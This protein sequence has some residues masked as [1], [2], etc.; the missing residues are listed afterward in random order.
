MCIQQF[1]VDLGLFQVAQLTQE[2]YPKHSGGYIKIVYVGN[3]YVKQNF[4]KHVWYLTNVAIFP[5][6]S[7]IPWL[8]KM[9]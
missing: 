2:T 1:Y 8:Q 6:L 4:V 9:S 3:A 7:E 5:A